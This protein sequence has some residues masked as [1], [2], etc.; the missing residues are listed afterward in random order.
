LYCH[1]VSFRRK[2]KDEK[3]PKAAKE[4][5]KAAP[6]AKKPAAKE[7]KK[8]RLVSCLMVADNGKD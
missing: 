1:R 6:E 3:D 4:D 5:A 7:E 2:K 8:V